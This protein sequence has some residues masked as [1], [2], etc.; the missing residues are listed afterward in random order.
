MGKKGMS[1]LLG[2]VWVFHVAAISFIPS[3]PLGK[4]QKIDRIEKVSE[5]SFP[6]ISVLISV[7]R[8][9]IPGFVID[10]TLW[11]NFKPGWPEFLFLVKTYCTSYFGNGSKSM[12]FFDVKMTFVHF[13]YPW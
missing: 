1:L 3:Q 10:W 5:A 4:S 6:A 2:F 12:P 7:D 11:S 9:V 13:F 8:P